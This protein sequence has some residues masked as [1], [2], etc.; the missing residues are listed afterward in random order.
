MPIKNL[1][2]EGP[3]LILNTSGVICS[4]TREIVA[5][6]IFEDVIARFAQSLTKH[7]SPLLDRLKLDLSQQGDIDCLVSIIRVLSVNTLEQLVKLLPNTEHLLA[8][9][10]A[11]HQLIEELYDFWR[12]FDR[13]MVCH[14]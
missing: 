14:S 8:E 3:Q 1:Q 6:N 2:Q 7:G 4:N 9:R 12:Q 13:F 5:S 11:L 10:E